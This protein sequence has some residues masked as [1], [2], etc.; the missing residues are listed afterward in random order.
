VNPLSWQ[1]FFP[2]VYFLACIVGFRLTGIPASFRVVRVFRGFPHFPIPAKSR[3]LPLLA[4]QTT[5]RQTKSQQA[6]QLR[7]RGKSYGVT[8]GV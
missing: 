2:L 4:A 1:S 3:R 6:E 8:S 5:R 7:Q